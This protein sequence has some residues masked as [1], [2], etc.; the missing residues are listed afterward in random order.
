[1]KLKR[2]CKWWLTRGAVGALGVLIVVL[3]AG[4][5]YTDAAVRQAE[6]K[7]P[8]FE[9][10]TVEGVRLHYVDEG[11]GQ[12]VVFFHAANG[13]L[14]H[15]TMSPMFEPLTQ[16]YR[17]IV[18]DR[19]GLGYSGQPAGEDATPAVQAR[20]IHGALQQLGVQKPVLV[21]QSWGGS[22]ALAYALEYPDDLSGIVLLGAVPYP[23]LFSDPITGLLRVPVLGD[24]VAHTVYVP[25]GQSVLVP[26]TVKQGEQAGYFP[27]L[28]VRPPDYYDANAALVLRPT[29]IEAEAEQAALLYPSNEALSP[30]Y[31]EIRVPVLIVIGDSDVPAAVEQAP[32]LDKELLHSKMVV[33]PDT[34]HCHQFTDPEGVIAAIRETWAWADELCT[35]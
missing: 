16:E 21:G 2:G 25:I 12:P 3:M 1:M 14:R 28:N 24:L 31:G 26:L 9:F 10:V 15:F 33:L 30:R 17:A 6:T 27:P 29:H 5:L 20:L 13:H 11:V 35:K 34:G 19:P 32:R 4:K 18:F 7:Y 23:Q 22:A 8:P